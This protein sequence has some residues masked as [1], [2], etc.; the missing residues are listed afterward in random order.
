ML[1][2]TIESH[3]GAAEFGLKYQQEENDRKNG[4]SIQH[5]TSDHQVQAAR[6]KRHSVKSDHRQ[7]DAQG[8]S[9]LGPP[10][11][12][13]ESSCEDQEIN[14]NL[15]ADD[16]QHYNT[17]TIRNFQAANPPAQFRGCPDRR[18]KASTTILA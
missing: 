4:G 6:Q 1:Q 15:P 13:V 5:P 2:S 9:G 8:T 14:D 16:K 7:R 18:P 12:S 17:A 10:E 11:Q 3:E